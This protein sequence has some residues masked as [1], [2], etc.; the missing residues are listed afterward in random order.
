MHGLHGS[1]ALTT[2]ENVTPA[3]NNTHTGKHQR[4]NLVTRTV[5]EHGH[6]NTGL[7][8]LCPHPQLGLLPLSQLHLLIDTLFAG[9]PHPQP[10][11][12]GL[13]SDWE[14]DPFPRSQKS[15]PWGILRSQLF[16]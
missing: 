12:A 4:Q 15:R 16:R 3:D 8:S 10:E 11:K 1:V 2:S 14:G 9:V 5:F 7:E 13:A 6:V